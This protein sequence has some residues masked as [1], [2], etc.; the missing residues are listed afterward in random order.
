MHWVH[1]SVLTM[2]HNS[3]NGL[4]V[5]YRWDFLETIS[6]R[7]EMNE[8]HGLCHWEAFSSVEA[9]LQPQMPMGQVGVIIISSEVHI[10]ISGWESLME[11]P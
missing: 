7:T 9:N 4:D 6:G 8:T 5:S 1:L 11:V 10:R 2:S 3:E